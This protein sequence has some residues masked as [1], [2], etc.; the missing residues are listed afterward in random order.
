MEAV[1]L[2]LKKSEFFNE[3]YPKKRSQMNILG[4]LYTE[5][6]KGNSEGGINLCLK[7]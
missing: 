4:I 1:Y 7:N 2:L 5:I 6:F 3:Y